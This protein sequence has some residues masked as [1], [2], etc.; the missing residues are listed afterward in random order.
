V[1]DFTRQYCAYF[2]N[3]D[4]MNSLHHEW[5]YN[6]PLLLQA[7]LEKKPPK[8]GFDLKDIQDVFQA[9]KKS[10]L[11]NHIFHVQ[12]V[13]RNYSIQAPSITAL[14]LWMTC[15]KILPSELL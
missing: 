10:E 1:L 3:E 5:F 4:V 12:T 14:N 13:S 9:N 11:I 8:G 6:D 2:E 7:C 15:L